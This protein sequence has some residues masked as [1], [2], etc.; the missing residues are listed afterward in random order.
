VNTGSSTAYAEAFI[1]G[2]IV[3]NAGGTLVPRFAQN[4]DAGTSS[5][6]TNSYFKIEQ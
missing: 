6:L 3:V 4:F 1:E 5:I 2:T